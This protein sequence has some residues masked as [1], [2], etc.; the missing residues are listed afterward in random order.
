MAPPVVPSFAVSRI[1]P[2]SAG[3]SPRL[4]GGHS[5]RRR[6][7]GVCVAFARHCGRRVP[8]RAHGSQRRWFRGWR[9]P[10]WLP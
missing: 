6:V 1:V 2:C 3:G 4:A 7:A 9:G 10:R 8:I 5:P